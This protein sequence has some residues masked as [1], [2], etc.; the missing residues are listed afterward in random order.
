MPHSPP[1]VC[2]CGRWYSSGGILHKVC[3][4]LRVPSSSRELMR[5]VRRHLVQRRPIPQ[6]G[7]PHTACAPSQGAQSASRRT[8]RDAVNTK[9]YQL[10]CA[11]IRGNPPIATATSQHLEPGG[12]T[13][14]ALPGNH[15]APETRAFERD[16]RKAPTGISQPRR[17]ATPTN[18]AEPRRHPRHL[19]IITLA[20]QRQ[21]PQRQWEKGSSV[22]GSYVRSPAENDVNVSQTVLCDSR[23]RCEMAA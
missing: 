19:R 9:S 18:Y 10:V 3:D 21:R 11:V 14:I 12:L 5:S 16:P 1:P 4:K 17:A 23:R 22:G 20:N 6:R 7:A 15:P 8:E 13:T 2:R